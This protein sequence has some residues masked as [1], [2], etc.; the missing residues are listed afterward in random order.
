MLVVLRQAGVIFSQENDMNPANDTDADMGPITIKLGSG[1][2]ARAWLGE[3]AYAILDPESRSVWLFRDIGGSGTPTRV[4]H[5]RA[6]MLSIP[7]SA[8][9]DSVADVLADMADDIE[10]VFALYEGVVWDGHNHVG[11][12]RGDVDDSVAEKVMEDLGDAMRGENVSCYWDA[13]AYLGCDK[14]GVVAELREALSAAN[15][16]LKEAIAIRVSMEIDNA[17]S[18]GCLLAEGEVREVLTRW[19][20]ETDMGRQTG[21]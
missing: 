13:D 2:A 17:A 4:W 21:S 6:R 8:E 11:V 19:A 7:A 14:R 20:A 3:H 12:W 18:G 9:L 15:G 10:S 5:R 16:D 1:R